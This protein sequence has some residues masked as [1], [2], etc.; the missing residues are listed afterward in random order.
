[1]V[2]RNDANAL[3]FLSEGNF[4]IIKNA[5][6]RP[7]KPQKCHG[8]RRLQ[9][10]VPGVFKSHT[11]P[12]FIY[13]PTSYIISPTLASMIF[14]RAILLSIKYMFTFPTFAL[15]VVYFK[16]NIFSMFSARAIPTHHSGLTSNNTFCQSLSRMS[17]HLSVLLT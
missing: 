9:D 16:L 10:K 11:R 1:M 2:A 15:A 8:P 3:I 4:S 17:H 7:I 13:S 6:E 12:C 5:R 14:S